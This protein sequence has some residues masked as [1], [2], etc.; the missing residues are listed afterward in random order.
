[1]KAAASAVFVL[2]DIVVSPALS[3]DLNVSCAQEIGEGGALFQERKVL[4]E[5]RSTC[6]GVVN[7]SRKP[8]RRCPGAGA[9]RAPKRIAS[10]APF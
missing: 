1:M 4:R 3:I 6:P 9:G 7:S 10:A 8:M 5:Q 2:V